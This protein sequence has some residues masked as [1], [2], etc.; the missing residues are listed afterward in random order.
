MR[1]R[2]GWHHTMLWTERALTWRDY[3]LLPIP[4]SR[5]MLKPNEPRRLPHECAKCSTWNI[6]TNRCDLS[7]FQDSCICHPYVPGGTFQSGFPVAVR[8][9]LFSLPG[10]QFQRSGPRA[11]VTITRSASVRR[12]PTT[13]GVEVYWFA[14]WFQGS[15]WNISVED[16]GEISRVSLGGSS[17]ALLSRPPIPSVSPSRRG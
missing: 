3:K 2:T 16:P 10:F 6:P 11:A 1:R 12:Q 17:S 7:S 9:A 4:Y 8:A 14:N 5:A 13:F 15:T